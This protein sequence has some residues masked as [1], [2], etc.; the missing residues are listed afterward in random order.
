MVHA[1]T[2]VDFEDAAMRYTDVSNIGQCMSGH[3]C[4]QR[5]IQ[6]RMRETAAAE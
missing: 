1:G 2:V 6:A 3:A 5:C 4:K